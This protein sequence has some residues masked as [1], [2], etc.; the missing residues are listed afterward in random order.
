MKIML[1]GKNGQ[2][3]YELQRSMQHLGNVMA[4]GRSEMDLTD[5]RQIRRIIQEFKPAIIVN[6]AAYTAVDKAESEPE[7]AMLING[8]A[9]GIIA[10]EAMKVGA[11]LI[12]YSTDY[13]F[14]GRKEEAYVETD[15]P[16]PLNVYGKTKLAGEVAIRSSGVRHIIFRTSWV[17]GQHGNNFLKTVLRLAKD[18]GQLQI[19]DDQYGA[20]TWSRT[21]AESTAYVLGRFSSRRCIPDLSEVSGTY[22]LTAQGGTTWYGFAKSILANASLNHIPIAPI[23][24]EEYP[25]PAVRPKYSKMKSDLFLKTFC[26]LPEWEEALS[27]CQA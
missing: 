8:I 4:I 27:L 6:A 10:E 1:I 17:Y 26:R 9:P 12:H 20:P 15:S 3:G 7:V 14:D 22:H 5:S 24:T 25:V 16:S 21:I 19:V 23:S 18:R 2:V 13:V 11:Q